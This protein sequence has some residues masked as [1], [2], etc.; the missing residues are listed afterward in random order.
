MPYIEGESLRERLEREKQLPVDEAV[1]IA[2]DVA[3]ALHSAHKQGV[4]HRDVK[5][6]NILLS[7]GRP[8]VADFGIALAVSAAGGGRLTET[9]L[10]MGTPYYM[11][12]EQ[13]S[14]DREPT[15]ASD[16]Y[17]LGCVL[18][19]MLVGEP[20]YVGSSAQAVLA[21][22]L[23]EDAKAPTQ[24]RSSIPANV[25]AAIRKSLEKLPA[26]RFA[27]VADFAKALTDRGFRHGESIG[28]AAS[29]DGGPWNRVSITF[30]ALFFAASSLAAWGWLRPPLERG[31]QTRVAFTDLGRGVGSISPDGR[32]MLTTRGSLRSLHIRAADDME[33]REL[34][35]TERAAN[36]TFS[37]DG[38][39]VAFTIRGR[40]IFRVPIAGG[41]AVQIAEAGDEP[42]WG[43][44]DVLVFRTREGA[45]HRVGASGGEPEVLF[46]SDSIEARRPFLLPN[47]RGVVFG[48]NTFG[49][50]LNSR[51]MYLDI[52][53]RGVRQ[54]VESGS[55]PRYIP[56]G[57]LIYGHGSQALMGVPFDADAAEVTG[58]EIVLLSSV[59]V[60][61]EGRT[62]FDVSE[63][64]TAIYRP[65]LGDQAAYSI[66]LIDSSGQG[67][68]L[69]IES[70]AIRGLRFS[71]E[72]RRVAY[73]EG[74]QVWVYDLILGTR[75]RISEEGGWDPV[76]DPGG[77]F[78][79]FHAMTSNTLEFDGFRA[80]ADGSAPPEQ[81]FR[82]AEVTAPQVWLRDGR[83]LA[84]G[85]HPERQGADWNEN[86]PAISPNER[87]LAYVSNQSGTGEV[88]VRP[89]DNDATAAIRV[90]AEG[91]EPAWHPDGDRLYFW[92]DI[93]FVEVRVRADD[94]F[95]EL[96][97]TVLFSDP[98]YLESQL[99]ANYDVHPDGE[100]FVIARVEGT[101]ETPEGLIVVNW[102]T[103]L[104]ER[105][106]D[107]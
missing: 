14:A 62:S 34:P 79:A 77:E 64:G 45:I 92:E 65:G 33:Y 68:A 61:S 83:L 84:R 25:D 60:S 69:V 20:P 70:G 6:A 71:P 52:E 42:H 104:C 18:Y 5:P 49:D 26:D 94:R 53:T 32:S 48:T 76:W 98:T 102:F 67:E 47:G 105:M 91:R 85:T 46:A 100:R 74:A 106:G 8:L 55:H 4:I 75:L 89:F 17:S 1:R 44:P 99:W 41:P 39:S 22:I 63:T 97:R 12:P 29:A 16:V 15:P 51:I 78:V 93:D 36:G 2:T 31:V 37:P 66:E 82:L 58:A 40:G 13:A 9:G 59:E 7:E 54:L 81:L 87:W 19:E 57:H 35:N 88:Q 28:A 72:G 73:G 21:K 50:P 38:R 27:G 107:C 24:A 43:L 3:E 11:S 96:S 103:E 80:P 56:T 95:E 23:T 30:A 86:H 10:S 90:S 101:A